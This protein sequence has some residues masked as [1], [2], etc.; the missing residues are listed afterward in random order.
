M[1]DARGDGVARPRALA[2]AAAVAAVAFAATVVVT[3]V[4][5]TPRDVWWLRATNAVRFVAG[6]LSPSELVGSFDNPDWIDLTHAL[7]AG[8]WVRDHAAPGEQL[9]VRG[10]DPEIYY[11]AGRRYGGRFFWSSVLVT[12]ALEYRRDEWLAEDLADI[13]R[14]RPAWVVTFE[15]PPAG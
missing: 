11:F 6:R 1:R 5:L 3:C 8:H 2:P 10:Y 12:P 7:E 15:V 9:L 14:L 4:A 13:E